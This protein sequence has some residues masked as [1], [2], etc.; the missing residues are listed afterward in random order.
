MECL[1][2]AEIL[3]AAHDGELVDA[4]ELAQ[5][6]AHCGECA[7]CATFAQTLDRLEPL[8]APPAPPGLADRILERTGALAAAAA[9]A[10][11]TAPAPDAD[12][13]SHAAVT[14][15]EAPRAW[16]GRLIAFAS[17]AA[18]L[19]LA[20]GISSV[21][22]LG[23]MV[24]RTSES[25]STEEVVLGEPLAATP[26]GDAGAAADESAM[27]SSQLESPPYIAIDGAVWLLVGP[28]Q[29]DPSLL[30][31]VSTLTHALEDA[32]APIQRYAFSVPGETTTRY[33]RVVDGGYLEFSRVVRTLGRR[34]YGLMT[35]S[36]P[37][38]FG[39][40]PTL[41]GQFETPTE[42]DGSPTFQA[43][44]KDD[45]GADAYVPI[46]GQITNGFAIAPGTGPTDPAAGNP[47]WTWWVPLD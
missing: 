28:A 13:E 15:R 45:L 23:Q 10:R 7:S 24:G 1:R 39:E 11:S 41:P 19:V 25:A 18:V 29:P 5:A 16:S 46:T 12:T 40:W 43:I 27:R 14:F 42:A 47:N 34:P 36:P 9:E 21:V 30:T 26:E 4:S 17:V 31:T 35:G 6:T 32:D 44:A 37:M 2:A 22:L 20:I 3:A 8:M 38:R 33:V